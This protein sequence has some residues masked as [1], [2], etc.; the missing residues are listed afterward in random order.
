VSA[1]KHSQSRRVSNGASRMGNSTRRV[2]SPL[3]GPSHLNSPLTGLDRP[4]VGFVSRRSRL[5]RPSQMWLHARDL[6]S[7]HLLVANDTPALRQ[8]SVD[9]RELFCLGILRFQ[10]AEEAVKRRLPAMA[11]PSGPLDGV[12]AHSTDFLRV[13][14]HSFA[15]L[16]SNTRTYKVCTSIKILTEEAT[17]IWRHG[18]SPQ[19]RRRNRGRRA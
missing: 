11:K 3:E 18:T 2:G 17:N 8:H 12:C 16:L 15:K 14:L 6:P 10:V 19:K 7:C 1:S 5:L 4:L 13:Q 9:D